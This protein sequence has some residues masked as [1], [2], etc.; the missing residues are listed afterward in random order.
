MKIHRETRMPPP[1]PDSS[2]PSHHQGYAAGGSALPVAKS[3]LKLT[4]V[5]SDN[6]PNM[7]SDGRK[8]TAERWSMGR[9]AD[10]LASQLSQ[11]V[12]DRT[13]VEGIFHLKLE[14]IP[15]GL[16]KLGGR[17]PARPSQAPSIFTAIQEQLGLNLESQKAPVEVVV[18]DSA[19]RPS[20][21]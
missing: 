5:A 8:L 20:E 15:E 9:M 14:W 2:I 7:H 11:P 3:R 17:T 10:F 12:T 19:E 16:V 13:Q 6:L 1:P 18:V 4:R 21:N